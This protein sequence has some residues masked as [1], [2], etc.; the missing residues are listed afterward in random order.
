VFKKY[1][2]YF[3]NYKHLHINL[4]FYR[5]IEKTYSYSQ[6]LPLNDIH[7]LLLGPQIRSLILNGKTEHTITIYIYSY[8]DIKYY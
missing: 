3:F 8:N 6:G 7:T 1:L 5:N 2:I 4:L